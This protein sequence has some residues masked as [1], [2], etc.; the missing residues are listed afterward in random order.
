MRIGLGGLIEIGCR[1][2]DLADGDV[3]DGAAEQRLDLLRIEPVGGTEI[4]DGEIMLVVALID[5]GATIKCLCVVGIER[6][7]PVELVQRAGRL[8]RLCQGLALCG[9]SLGLADIAGADRAVGG[10]RSRLGRLLRLLLLGHHGA[11][12]EG[13]AAQHDPHQAERERLSPDVA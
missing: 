5:Q 7:G 2:L 11:Q 8:A 4:G 9:V 13:A 1:F 3:A 12:V 6:D 10:R